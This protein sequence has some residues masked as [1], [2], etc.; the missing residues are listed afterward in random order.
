MM[1][2]KQGLSGGAPYTSFLSV[3]WL[4]TRTV[5]EERWRQGG[6]MGGGG[7]TQEGSTGKTKNKHSTF[8]IIWGKQR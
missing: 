7:G 6:A 4:T 8:F 1:L 5:S 3:S 2:T